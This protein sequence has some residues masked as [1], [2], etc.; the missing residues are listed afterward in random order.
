MSKF[1]IT[2]SPP[3]NLEKNEYVIGRPDFS[4]FIAASRNKKPKSN[5][6]TVNYF[7]ELISAIGQ[8]YLGEN[9]DAMTAINA[10]RY[11]GSPCDSEEK[12]HEVLVKAFE[13]QCPQL[14]LAFVHD[15]FKRRP[16]GTSL[17]YYTG[18]P[19]FS[20]KLVELGLEQV[21]AKELT[22][23]KSGKAKKVVGKPA[24]T[25]EAAAALNR[26]DV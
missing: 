4:E 20:T 6:M 15:S 18:N 12:V 1:V 21:S 3:E 26:D 22:E 10:S 14:L 8:R 9:F 17:I 25:N 2:Q 13:T 11:V 16:R 23:E 7:R 5:V 19:R 24:I